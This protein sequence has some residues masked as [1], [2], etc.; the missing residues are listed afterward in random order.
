MKGNTFSTLVLTTLVSGALSVTTAQ[1][2][3]NSPL[4]LT[5]DSKLWVEG[6]STVRD[7][8]CMAKVMDATISGGPEGTSV[9]LAQV[10]KS[11]A[12][13]VEVAA[14]DCSNGTMNEHMRKA[15][16]ASEA[17][18]ITFTLDSYELNDGVASLFGKL[19]MAGREHAITIPAAVSEEG[20]LI[21]VTASKAIN[22]KEWGVKP[23]S[24]M[25][26]TMK[27]K[28]LVTINFD[29]TLKR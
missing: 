12:V 13:T 11:A 10:V 6:K 22:M 25:L 18:T 7:Y 9:P 19:Q 21:R 2:G 3:P 28:E 15:L 8:K 5:A 17:P 24:L 16:K 1:S 20:D 27:V 29:V 4:T 26:G 23:P 14:L